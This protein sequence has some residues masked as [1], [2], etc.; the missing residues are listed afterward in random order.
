MAREFSYFKFISWL[1]G[2]RIESFWFRTYV[3]IFFHCDVTINCNTCSVAHCATKQTH[4]WIPCQQ[5]IPRLI[6]T[7]NLSHCGGHKSTVIAL[8]TILVGRVT[9][10]SCTHS[11]KLVSGHN[12][13]YHNNVFWS[14]VHHWIAQS[15]DQVLAPCGSQKVVSMTTF[16]LW[17]GRTGHGTWTKNSLIVKR[18]LVANL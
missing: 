4:R 1:K 16:Q 10:T 5:H 7:C 18:I 17:H 3:P 8:N 6:K 9:I 14:T 12:Q 13:L 11:I 2:K 15:W